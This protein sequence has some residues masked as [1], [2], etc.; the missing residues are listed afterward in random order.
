MLS[1]AYTY[2]LAGSAIPPMWQARNTAKGY[3]NGSRSSGSAPA[4]RSTTFTPSRTNDSDGQLPWYGSSRTSDP[5]RTSL[6]SENEA[7]TAGTATPPTCIHCRNP[8]T[9]DDG[10][11]THPGCDT[12]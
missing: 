9:Y 6:T 7:G 3:R 8:L 2:M 4:K 1:K 5:S 10:T 12:E 11:H